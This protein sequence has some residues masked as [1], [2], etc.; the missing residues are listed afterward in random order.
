M[1]NYKIIGGDG[2]QYGPVTAEELRQWIA[3]GRLNGQSL[4]QSEGA[5]DWKSANCSL[6]A[7]F[8]PASLSITP[9]RAKS[10]ALISVPWPFEWPLAW[11]LPLPFAWPLEALGVGFAN[12]AVA[13]PSDFFFPPSALGPDFSAAGGLVF[14]AGAFVSDFFP[15]IAGIA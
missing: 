11:P 3:E 6:R 13:P 1:A 2:Q 7:V 10:A 15:P 9:A 5:S 4:V 14:E 12:V 8:G